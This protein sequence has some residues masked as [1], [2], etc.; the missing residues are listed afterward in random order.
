MQYYSLLCLSKAQNESITIPFS[1]AQVLV[2]SSPVHFIL[3]YLFY[4]FTC[5]WTFS[6]SS[7]VSDTVSKASEYLKSDQP[8]QA[9]VVLDAL[10]VLLLA[11]DN[12]RYMYVTQANFCHYPSIDM[13]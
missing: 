7:N 5:R 8:S 10:T 12:D 11:A 1:K 13:Y 3:F 2:K 4:F 9:A 6:L